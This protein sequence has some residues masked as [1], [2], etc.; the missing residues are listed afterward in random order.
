M[1]G[2]RPGRDGIMAGVQFDLGRAWLT[3]A[4]NPTRAGLYVSYNLPTAGRTS[5]R[6]YDAAGKVVASLHEG[7]QLRGRHNLTWSGLARDG[8]SLASGVYFLT[9]EGPG[10]RVAEKLVI[11]R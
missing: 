4:P 9:L 5:V 2:A 7:A 8:R 1:F 6:V 11:Q 10:T 3:A